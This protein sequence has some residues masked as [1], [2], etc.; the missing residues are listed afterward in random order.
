[1]PLDYTYPPVRMPDHDGT[2]SESS[3]KHE[4]ESK[5]GGSVG[6][7]K[8]AMGLFGGLSVAAAAKYIHDQHK[9]NSLTDDRFSEDSEVEL[10]TVNT[11]SAQN[12]NS[13]LV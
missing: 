11:A 1:M 5:S 12:G 4:D 9:T 8:I 3:S 13:Q 2:H 6:Y 7:G 10:A